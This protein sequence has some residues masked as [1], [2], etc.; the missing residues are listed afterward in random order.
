MKVYE[1]ITALEEFPAGAEV[2][3]SLVKSLSEM[4]KID[5]SPATYSIECTVRQTALS[6]DGTEV[7][8]DGW[9]E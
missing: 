2:K 6:D 5:N 4:R 3:I 8:V 1:M 7:T 9:K